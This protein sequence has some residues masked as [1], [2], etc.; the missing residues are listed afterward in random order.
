MSKCIPS[1]SMTA[2]GAVGGFPG[3]YRGYSVTVTTATAAINIRNG[4]GGQIIDVI[5]TGTTAGTTKFHDEGIS[6]DDG[7]YVDF[8][9]GTGTVV[10]FHE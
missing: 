10:V 6:L 3:V 8:T 7:V 1:A 2:S 5:P 9:T 4:S